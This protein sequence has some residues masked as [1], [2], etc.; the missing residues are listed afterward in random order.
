VFREERLKKE[1]VTGRFR[2]VCF[3]LGVALP[4]IQL[5]QIYSADD[6]R[7]VYSVVKMVLLVLPVSA[8]CFWAGFKKPALKADLQRDKERRD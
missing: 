6:G 4:L 3:L 1:P 7:F 8:L 2:V 5:W